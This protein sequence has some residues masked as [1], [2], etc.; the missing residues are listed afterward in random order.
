M[1]P[2]TRIKFVHPLSASYLYIIFITPCILHSLIPEVPDAAAGDAHAHVEGLAAGLG[3]R[4]VRAQDAAPA[5]EA[6]CSAWN[7]MLG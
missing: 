6:L 5:A 1:F 2:K 3:V 7:Q 4:I